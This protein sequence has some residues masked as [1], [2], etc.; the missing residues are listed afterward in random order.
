MERLVADSPPNDRRNDDALLLESPID[1]R[2]ENERLMDGPL[3]LPSLN[4]R[5]DGTLNDRPE[6]SPPLNE[7]EEPPSNERIDGE[8]SPAK[9]RE[10]PLNER[11]DS[12]PLN[13]RNDRSLP[14]P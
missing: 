9:L 3:E 13:D 6:R 7:R 14:P 1:G 10:G 12:P 2:P 11:D 5:A 8:L 4:V